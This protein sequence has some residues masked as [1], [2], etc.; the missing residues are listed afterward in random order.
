[1]H[2]DDDDNDDG[3]ADKDEDDDHDLDLDVGD[4]KGVGD[5]SHRFTTFR[6][7]LET[8]RVLGW[9]RSI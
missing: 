5:D 8:R 3:D 2:D 7:T 4:D 6:S 9:P 1:M